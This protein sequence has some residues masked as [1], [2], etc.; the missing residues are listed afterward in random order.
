M[1]VELKKELWRVFSVASF[2]FITIFFIM[3]YLI[4]ISTYYHEK[5][6]QKALAKYGVDSYYSVNL[7]ETIPNFFNPTVTK[8]GVTRFS[9]AE[10]FKLDKYQRA[11]V[12]IAGIVSDL[13]FLFLIGIYLAMTNVYVYYKIR[14]KKDYDLTWQIAINWILFM[15][16]LALV[17][18]TV[19]NITFRVGDIYHLIGNLRLL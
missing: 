13:R 8:L 9:E 19:S 15:W 10:Y 18:I 4:Q 2:L 1:D 3:P 7:L 17:Q 11:E 6:H 14:F 16:L 5:S 12:N